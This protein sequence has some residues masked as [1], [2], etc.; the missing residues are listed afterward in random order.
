MGQTPGKLTNCEDNFACLQKPVAVLLK[1][2]PLGQPIRILEIKGVMY[3]A[4][5]SGG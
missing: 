1:M 2:K 3:F 4:V 5:S